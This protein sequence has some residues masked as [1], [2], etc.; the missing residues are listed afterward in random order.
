MIHRTRK[1]LEHTDYLHTDD[2]LT[3]VSVCT[4]SAYYPSVNNN[5]GWNG[6]NSICVFNAVATANPWVKR[7][8]TEGLP[9]Q[10]GKWT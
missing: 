2:K 5:Y 10:L 6:N 8:C 3:T 9:W 4:D 7:M 1:Q